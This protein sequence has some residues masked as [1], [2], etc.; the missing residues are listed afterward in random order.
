MG[1]GVRLGLFVLAMALGVGCATA[2][3]PT[4]RAVA[5]TSLASTTPREA[6]ANAPG[7]PA[8]QA[9]GRS[10]EEDVVVT[11]AGFAVHSKLAAQRHARRA[12]ILAALEIHLADLV[13]AFPKSAQ[14]DLRATPIWMTERTTGGPFFHPAAAASEL[15]FPEAANAIEIASIDDTL[16]ALKE[17]KRGVF[18]PLLAAGWLMNRH[19]AKLEDAER[20]YATA[21]TKGRVTAGW[22]HDGLSYF[23]MLSAA[24]MGRWHVPPDRAQLR[25]DDPEGAALM[26]RTWPLDQLARRPTASEAETRAM[27]GFTVLVEKRALAHTE[28]R[29]ALAALEAKLA[30]IGKLVPA[31]ALDGVKKDVVVVMRW[32]DD[33][34]AAW[35][36][37]T[38]DGMIDILD[39]RTFL[40]SL[41]VD[42][43]A[44]VHEIA[45]VRTK[46]VPRE[47]W[48]KITKAFAAA[49]AAGIYDAVKRADG[50]VARAYA[51]TDEYE[52]FCELSKAYLARSPSFPFTRADLEKHDP[53]GFAAVADAWK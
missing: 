7:E 17:G 45:H 41:D 3:P 42:P 49:H 48:T 51:A 53:A 33:M 12:E 8:P 21:K 31:A 27:A 1:A 39:A 34:D 37:Y 35:Q 11:V 30:E 40:R 22:G 44:L 4:R 2:T 29:K 50:R 5:T 24:W 25:A 43:Y 14:I 6:N 15:A 18:A 38:H 20:T 23:A 28:T 36:L 10:E 16:A 26:A 52:Y 19:A 13:M 32:A 9:S 46:A 47:Q